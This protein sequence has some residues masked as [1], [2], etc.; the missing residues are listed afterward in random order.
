MSLFVVVVTI[1]RKVESREPS[2]EATPYHEPA[3]GLEFTS[4]A[5]PSIDIPAADAVVDDKGYFHL[6]EPPE[7]GTFMPPY[8]PLPADTSQQLPGD[9]CLEAESISVDAIKSDTTVNFQFM[10]ALPNVYFSN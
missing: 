7:L 10:V 1:F 4:D 8:T 3:S 5:M 9:S 2:P 6:P